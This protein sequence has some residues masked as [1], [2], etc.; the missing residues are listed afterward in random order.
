M[1]FAGCPARA[2]THDL[3]A[4]NAFAAATLAAAPEDLPIA[5]DLPSSG[6]SDGGEKAA[7]LPESSIWVM[8]LVW[9]AGLSLAL[10]W[11]RSAKPR[12]SVVE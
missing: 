7:S 12:L 10:V 8:M 2:A 5:D 11:R 6:A 1:L 3:G 4:V 9:F